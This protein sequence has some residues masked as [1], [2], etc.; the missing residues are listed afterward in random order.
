[1]RADA[2]RRRAA[3]V[4]AGRT[5]FAERGSDVALDAVADAAGVGIAT[6]YRN[7]DSR[8]ALLDEVALAILT[9]VGVVVDEALAGLDEGATA[10]WEGCLRRLVDLDLG[11]LTAALADHVAGA[12]SD[13]VREAQDRTLARVDALLVAARERHLVRADLSALELVVAIG[14]VTRPQPEAVLRAAPDLQQR[15]AS[16]LLAGLRPEA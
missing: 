5:L 3:I 7:F 2:A 4:H 8:A 12:L 9:D 16:I 1:M 14:M 15:L 6:L 10:A 13:R 11:A